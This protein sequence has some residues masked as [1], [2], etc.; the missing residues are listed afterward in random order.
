MLEAFSNNRLVNRI[1]TGDHDQLKDDFRTDFDNFIDHVTDVC[2]DPYSW[3]TNN[4]ELIK[5]ESNLELY[6]MAYSGPSEFVKL[7]INAILGFIH[8]I[9]DHFSHFHAPFRLHRKSALAPSDEADKSTEMTAI[10]E[11]PAAEIADIELIEA[12][13]F[14]HASAFKLF[15]RLSKSRVREKVNEFTGIYFTDRQMHNNF[16]NIK[17]RL[18][19]DHAQFLRRWHKEFNDDLI[20]RAATDDERK[21]ANRK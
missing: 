13:E 12:I 2:A 8:K 11:I 19:D 9:R 3:H 21:K 6:N 14:A 17:R 7:L 15:P 4:A 20:V 1:L 18:E 10:K 16:S 5:L